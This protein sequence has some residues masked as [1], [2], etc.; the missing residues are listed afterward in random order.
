MLRFSAEQFAQLARLQAL[1]KVDVALC[2]HIPEWAQSE[3]KARREFI[4][5][6][7]D[8]A[9]RYG[10]RSGRS[11]LAYTYCAIWHGQ[12]FEESSAL[13]L[14]LLTSPLPQA[15]KTHAMFAWDDDRFDPHTSTASGDAAIRRS[16]E[17]TTPW[18]RR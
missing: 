16:L 4:G 2:N 13:L 10:L 5:I 3:P 7:I 11:V 18:G 12:M 14:L 8:R 17:L 1:R 9:A 6:C 15:R